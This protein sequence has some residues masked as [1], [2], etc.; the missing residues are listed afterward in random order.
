MD[1][2]KLVS[3][4]PRTRIVGSYNGHPI[5]V[6]GPGR[7]THGNYYFWPSLACAWA[8]AAAIPLT[9]VGVT[10]Q[11]A[12]SVTGHHYAVWWV[13]LVGM[14]GASCSGWAINART[15]RAGP[16]WIQI[17]IGQPVSVQRIAR[18][19]AHTNYRRGWLWLEYADG[20]RSPAIPLHRLMRSPAVAG[21]LTDGLA[22]SIDANSEVIASEHAAEVIRQ[23]QQMVQQARDWAHSAMS[24][25]AS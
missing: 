17:G 23:M 24:S 15:L 5:V 16:G 20:L 6:C 4:F 21:V 8:L 1:D 19:E 3:T 2:A 7:F 12:W 11:L 25:P 18:V 22:Q 13:L 10:P 14:L 9:I